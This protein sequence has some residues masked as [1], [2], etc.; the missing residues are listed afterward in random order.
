MMPL[1]CAEMFEKH[2]TKDTHIPNELHTST[3]RIFRGASSGNLVMCGA[4]SLRPVR[5]L[6][7][8]LQRGYGESPVAGRLHGSM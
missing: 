7:I 6:K 4:S 5:Y 1:T 8:R 3:E 2:Q